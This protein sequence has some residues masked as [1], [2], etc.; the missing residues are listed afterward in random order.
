MSSPGTSIESHPEGIGADQTLPAP[1]G[2]EGV[3]R[4]ALHH[5]RHGDGRPLLLVGPAGVG[6]SAC[7]LAVAKRLGRPVAVFDV[8]VAGLR[9]GQRDGLRELPL[10][11]HLT[12]KPMVAP[13]GAAPVIVI[14]HAD[15]LPG[16]LTGGLMAAMV[17]IATE[18]HPRALE[19]YFGVESEAESTLFVFTTR[20]GASSGLEAS[21]FVLELVGYSLSEKAAIAARLLDE[22]GRRLP[23]ALVQQLVRLYARGPGVAAITTL[24]ENTRELS[25]DEMRPDR[26]VALL[27]ESALSRVARY[28]RP[29]PGQAITMASGR[30]FAIEVCFGT[31]TDGDL[32]V[33]GNVGEVMEGAARIALHAANATLEPS[34][35]LGAAEGRSVLMNLP[36]SWSNAGAAVGLAM[37]LAM[38]GLAT[39]R[40]IR[41]GVAVTGELSLGGLV[42]PVR[43]CTAQLL[44]A[45]PEELDCVILPEGNRGALRDVA[46]RLRSGLAMGFVSTFAEAIALSFV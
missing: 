11:P 36:G 15:R 30:A 13:R 19:H 14:E 22:A 2:L 43:G 21:S 7:A 26:V 29:L 38:V 37:G 1:V 46:A 44:A 40:S 28:A 41:P 42:L 4:A 24:I 23:G 18:R 8:A 3:L 39:G 31:R 34:R 20:V 16:G 35:R 32:K 25:D 12:G 6:K 17:A 45:E 33:L 10:V 5:V 27:G 9:L